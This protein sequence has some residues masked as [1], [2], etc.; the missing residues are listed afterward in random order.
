[1]AKVESTNSDG[2]TKQN[3]YITHYIMQDIF[4]ETTLSCIV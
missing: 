3:I 2:K 4:W 1:M